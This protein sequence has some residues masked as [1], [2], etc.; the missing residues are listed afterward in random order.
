MLVVDAATGA[1]LASL[2]IGEGVDGCAF[3]ADR[4]LAFCSQGDGSL[5]VVAEEKGGYVVRQN[6][7]T[8]RGARTL[9]LDPSMDRIYL[10]TADFDE[11]PAKPGETRPRRAMRANTFV[12]LVVGSDAQ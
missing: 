12:L 8:R 1:R 5:T 10:V 4:R 6:A 3:D 7:V 11:Q 9:A 2:P